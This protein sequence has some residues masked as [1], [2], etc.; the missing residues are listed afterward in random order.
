M[1]ALGGEELGPGHHLGVLLEECAAL[2]LG[3]PAPHAELDAVVEGVGPAFEDDRAVPADDCG[4]AL[5]RAAD[6]QFVGIGL[7][8]SSSGNPRD[9]SLGLSA[10]DQIVGKSVGSCPTRYWPCARHQRFPLSP[11]AVYLTAQSLGVERS[12]DLRHIAT[13]FVT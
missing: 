11:A 13:V 9:S 7:S 10:L 1:F 5:G 8:A 2:T 4:F 3:H 12:C 6:E